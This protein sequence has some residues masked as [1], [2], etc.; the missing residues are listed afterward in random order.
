MKYSH[1]SQ[2]MEDEIKKLVKGK[3]PENSHLEYKREIKFS[4]EPEKKELLADVCSFANS[5]GGAIIYGIE[6]GKGENSGLPE[7]I[8]GLTDN[9][10]ETIRSLDE[11]I[12]KGIEPVLVGVLIESRQIDEKKVLVLFIPKSSNFPHR[13]CFKNTKRFYKRAN[14]SKYEIPI[15]ELKKD[16]LRGAELSKRISEFRSERITKIL[17]NDTPIILQK[18]PKLA[19]H[20]I[21]VY[22]FDNSQSFESLN[23]FET[24]EFIPINLL[25]KSNLL[26]QSR[27]NFDGYVTY[28]QIE[29]GSSF[30]YVQIFRNS[31]VEAVDTSTL[32]LDM[33]AHSDSNL[34]KK[35]NLRPAYEEQVIKALNLYCSSLIKKSINGPCVVFLSLLDIKG[36]KM[37]KNPNS[38]SL[39]DQKTPIDRAHLLLPDMYVEDMSNF[40]AQKVMKPAF[41]IVWNA[42]GCSGSKNYD[43]TGEWKPSE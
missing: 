32:T 3:V 39:L 36:Y 29:G 19:L 9:I 24:M 31:S 10:D 1:I 38:A 8:T 22:F 42:C 43:K 18:Y 28:H 37:Y 26:P 33:A 11:S 6:E 2:I 16:F 41:D 27:L 30:S 14:A 25:G 7:Q 35:G 15:E 34:F 20:I 40:S 4:S 21:P 13:V 12:R 5:G 17:S 23:K